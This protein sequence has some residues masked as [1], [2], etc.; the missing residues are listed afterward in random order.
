MCAHGNAKAGHT[1]V[2]NCTN[3]L[4]N[5]TATNAWASSNPTIR[6]LQILAARCCVRYVS[7]A[8]ARCENI[9]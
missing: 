6:L 3:I 1:E 5:N 4:E 7:A 9:Q 8:A 2:H